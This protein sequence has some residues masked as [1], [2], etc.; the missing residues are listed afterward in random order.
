[1][2]EYDDI[3]HNKRKYAIHSKTPYMQLCNPAKHSYSHPHITQAYKYT[4]CLYLLLSLLHQ[5]QMHSQVRQHYKRAAIYSEANTI[6]PQRLHIEAKAAQ[7]SRPRDFDVQ[8]VLVVDER[9]VL[10]LVYNQAFERVVEDG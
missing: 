10:D 2:H 7:D 6:P 5:Q 3:L 4:P 9:E 8:S 1:M